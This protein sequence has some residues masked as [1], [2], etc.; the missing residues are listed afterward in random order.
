[1]APA[2]V[3]QASLALRMIAGEDGTGKGRDKI[4]TLRRNANLFRA[5]LQRMGCEVSSPLPPR[6]LS[7]LCV[8][9]ARGRGQPGDSGDALQ[10][11]ED[12]GVLARVPCAQARGGGGGLPGDAADQVAR[13]LLHQ[14]RAHRERPHRRAA[15]GR[16]GG[17][18]GHGQVQVD[19]AAQRVAG[20]GGGEPDAAALLR[21]RRQL[22]RGAL[23]LAR[24]PR[25]RGHGALC[26]R[27]RRP[28]KLEGEAGG[29]GGAGDDPVPGLGPVAV[30]GAAAARDGLA[31]REHAAQAH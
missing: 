3:T 26:A 7:V 14:R 13:A 19:G 22:G 4:E 11:R 10:P 21:G 5:G 1:M 25:D 27:Q 29:R 2:A 30:G 15:R 23:H 31:A 24:L 12:P 18:Q 28:G 9:S 17:G 6:V 16:R 20:G 8:L